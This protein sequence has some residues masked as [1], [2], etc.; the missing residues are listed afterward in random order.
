MEYKRVMGLDVGDKRIGIAMSD[1]LMITAQGLETYTRQEESE[2]IAH[3]AS[4]YQQNGC[5]AI[6]CG[7]PLNMDG[8]EG[9]QA[10]KV[11]DFAAKVGQACGTEVIFSDERLTTVLSEKVLIQ[12]DM[13]RQKRRKVIDKV[14]AVTILQGY[15]DSLG[16][17]R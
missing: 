17:Q 1:L 10:E 7:L 5:S 13:S 4:L 8:T 12:A 15:L 11:K 9:F 14:A 3:I 6:V 16:N 2:D